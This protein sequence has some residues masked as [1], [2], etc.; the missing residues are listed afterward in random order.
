MEC[1][2]VNVIRGAMTMGMGSR[3][4]LGS[5]QERAAVYIGGES[6]VGDDK[7]GRAGWIEGGGSS[8]FRSQGGGWQTNAHPWTHRSESL[9]SPDRPLRWVLTDD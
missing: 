3:E 2:R 9:L 1:R 5:E 4:N 6:P 7:S 8:V